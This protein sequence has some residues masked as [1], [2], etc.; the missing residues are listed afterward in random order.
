[1]LGLASSDTKGIIMFPR[2]GGEVNKELSIYNSQFCRFGS[3]NSAQGSL[4]TS[5]A[6]TGPSGQREEQICF[7]VSREVARLN[8]VGCVGPLRSRESLYISIG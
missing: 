5:L 7:G 6:R 8:L 1:M 3:A 2:D 4:S